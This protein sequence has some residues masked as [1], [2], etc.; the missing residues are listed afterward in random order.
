M[1]LS[2]LP[3]CDSNSMTGTNGRRSEAFK[4]GR[5][6]IAM[7]HHGVTSFW[8]NVKAGAVDAATLVNVDVTWLPPNGVFDVN[9]MAEQVS[10][11]ADS[12]LYD[13]LVVTIPSSEIASAVIQV[14]REHVGLPIVVM[15]VGMQTAAQLGV[16]AVLQDEIAAGELIGNA[17]LDRGAQDFLCL[18]HS[19]KVD[20][21]LDR[22]TGVLK[23]FLARGKK[24][25]EIVTVN[26]T[27]AFDINAMNTQESFDQVAKYLQGHPTVDTI[28]AL[29]IPT[30]NLAL[31]VSMNET[32]HHPAPTQVPGRNGTMWIGTFDVT[33]DVIQAVKNNSVAVAISQTPYVQG[34]LPVIELFLQVSTKQ[35]LI[36]NTLFT[37]PFLLNG[38]N[39][40]SEYALDSFSD[41][42]NFINRKKTAVVLNRDIAFESTRWNEA[43]GGVV[44]AASLFG[45]DTISATSMQQLGSIQ[46]ELIRTAATPNT[47]GI[48]GV[49]VS[50]ADKVQFNELLTTPALDPATPIFGLGSTANWTALPSRV[51]FTGPS[52]SGIGNVFASQILSSGY[53]VPLCL[54]EE[55][56]P[57]WQVMH[58]TELHE[59]LTKVYGGV[60]VGKLSDMMLVVPVNGSDYTNTNMTITSLQARIGTER[61]NA[62]NPILDAF[63]PTA[64][65]AFDSI[66]CTSQLLYSVVD[67]LYP[68]LRKVRSFSAAFSSSQTAPEHLRKPPSFSRGLP[69]PSSPG[70]FVV[71]I[72][73]KSLYSL[74]H[75]QQVTGLLDTQQYLQGFHAILMLS[76]RK[77]FPQRGKIFNQFLATGPV[78]INHVCEPG[79]V[80][81]SS[82][83]YG[84]LDNTGELQTM[85]VG[86]TEVSSQ[87]TYSTM[88]CHSDDGH[89]LLQS[90]CSRCAVGTISTQADAFECT[91]CPAGQ[92]TNGTGQHMCTIC[93]DDLCGTSSMSISAILA[94]VLPL[95][96]V[97]CGVGA[98]I[99]Y[100]LK[101]KRILHDKL[102]DDSWQLDLKKLLNPS[103]GGG[104]E[105]ANLPVISASGNGGGEGIILPVDPNITN[106]AM[107]PMRVVS[108]TEGSGARS[109]GAR[110]TDEKEGDG[111]LP[112]PPRST[113]SKPGSDHLNMNASTH[114]TSSNN[115][116]KLIQSALSGSNSQFS[117][118]LNT[119]SSAVGTWRSMPVFIKKIGCKKVPITAELRKEIYNMRELRHPKLV[120]FIG[121]CLAPPNICIVTEFVPKGTLAS[122]LANADHKLSWQFK[123]S[124]IEDL[125]RGMEFL[126]MSKMERHGRLTSFNCMISSRWELKI[127]GYGLDGLFMSQED[128]PLLST[129][130]PSQNQQE[131]S[132]SGH[133]H[134]QRNN[135]RPWSDPEQVCLE[136]NTQNTTSAS[137]AFESH[138]N[139]PGPSVSRKNSSS[140]KPRESGNSQYSSTAPL[141]GTFSH[142]NA[143]SDLPHVGSG[144]D[145]ILDYSAF[146]TDTMCLLWVAP[147]CLFLN[148][149]G[150][151][152]LVGTQKGDQY[153]AGII[154]N[155][156]LTRKLPYHDYTDYP[157][158]L[159]LV[160]NQDF[161]PTLLNPEYASYTAED[162][163]NIEQ[164]NNLILACI[165]KDTSL[166]PTFTTMVN[167]VN[168]IN[169]HKTDDFITS[170]AAMLEKYGN[171]M[172]D[173]VRDR[174]KNLQMRTIELEEE[175]ARTHRLLV[176]LQKAK[177]GAEA[178]ALA[179]SNFLANMSHE[180]R[181]PMNAVIGMS[182]I[183]LDS[184]L[185][186][187][188]AE[189][190]ETIE[191]SGNQ[192]MT[193][194]DD[195][196][197]YSKIESGNLKLES[198]LL[199]LGFVV[200]S[201]VNLISAQAAAKDLNLVYEIA[202]DCPVEIMGD[203]TRIRQ[204][205]LNLMSN[206]VKFTKEGSIHL[207][208]KVE[209]IQAI[210]IVEAAEEIGVTGPHRPGKGSR[211][212]TDKS[213][214][215]TREEPSKRTVIIPDGHSSSDDSNPSTLVPLAT[216]AE[217]GTPVSPTFTSTSETVRGGGTDTECLEP[218]HVFPA[219]T[220]VKLLFAVKDTGV[221]IP[222]DRF[223]KLFTSFSQVDESTTREYG[224]TGLGLAISKRLSE[225]MGGHMWV[226]SVPNVGSTFFFNIILD[227]PAG[228][229]TYQEHFEFPRLENKRLVIVSDSAPGRDAWK[230]RTDSWGMKQVRIFNSDQ[231]MSYLQERPPAA[232]GEVQS[233]APLGLLSKMETLI[234]DSD[235]KGSVA[236]TPEGLMDAIQALEPKTGTTATLEVDVEPTTIPVI[237]FKNYRD[238]NSAASFSCSQQSQTASRKGENG[239][240]WSS[241][242]GD[243][244]SISAYS[245]RGSHT[246]GSR[247]GQDRARIYG[248][249]Y[250]L[251]S[252]SSSSSLSL[253]KTGSQTTHLSGVRPFAANMLSP[254]QPSYFDHNT[255]SFDHG[256]VSVSP[257]ASLQ[258]RT[259]YFS[260]DN[261]TTS[262]HDLTMTRPRVHYDSLGQSSSLIS[263]YHR[264]GILHPLV[265]LTKPVR[266]SKI[267]Q[268]LLEDP[269]DLEAGLDMGGGGLGL[270]GGGSGMESSGLIVMSSMPIDHDLDSPLST[271]VALSSVHPFQRLPAVA[272]ALLP[273]APIM[274]GVSM[275]LSSS[276]SPGLTLD[277]SPA[278]L[279]PLNLGLKDANGGFSDSGG[280]A[281]GRHRMDSS[282]GSDLRFLVEPQPQPE[283]RA[284]AAAEVAETPV[285]TRRQPLARTLAHSTP[286]RKAVSVNADR[287]GGMGTPMSANYNNYESPLIAAAAAA[288]NSVAMRMAKMKVLVVD[289]NP[290][291]LKVASK[292]LARLGIEPE[293]ANNGQDAVE[294]I[295]RK[296]ALMQLQEGGGS[297]EG[298]APM[299][300][301][302]LAE[303]M[304]T[305]TTTTTV[306]DGDQEGAKK[307]F[308]PYDLIFMDVWMPKMNG[309]D[310]TTYI[311]KK[312]SGQSG[313]RPY[314]I[315]MTACVMEG[316]REKCIA[317]GMND[318][319][320]KP[321]RKEELEQ[322]LRTFVEH[323]ERTQTPGQAAS[324]TAAETEV[325]THVQG[326][327]HHSQR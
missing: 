248:K 16:L 216:P 317:S 137:S 71:D 323:Y 128:T 143:S 110:S 280:N 273:P 166:R 322:S 42:F 293:T 296:M 39:I 145:G 120:E 302:V 44:E 237:I 233:L 279:P 299:A 74:S 249:N 247:G 266:H 154:F 195:I 92:R 87:V 29:T 265:Y 291:N 31:R 15:N 239:S 97:I 36:Q 209:P 19:R 229:R 271:T 199:D 61:E 147:E 284:R 222:Q 246:S 255:I 66:M 270:G 8:A 153:S 114:S 202:R 220:P 130:Q 3:S 215:S 194:I 187:E 59:F 303:P 81:S 67:S 84:L 82:A 22:C 7:I 163:E 228:S 313:D 260:S 48:E 283:P 144:S 210:R 129:P 219:S 106:L 304:P 324:P 17:L 315:S 89:V 203:I 172:E 28:V 305:T 311:R 68:S 244:G 23:A 200:E 164:M 242:T 131:P 102:N 205:L 250:P 27:L 64:R 176:D 321:L 308:V 86:S 100:W 72:S 26:K 217:S 183:L 294:L 60:K 11:T 198:R 173:L 218:K 206:A 122:V 141:Q 118:V 148:S 226:E 80:F 314:V 37:G 300:D 262:P 289:D 9:A 214:K 286:R 151:Y 168:D 142:V 63:S 95:V 90:W 55:N 24:L 235:L 325:Q 326:G 319:I 251:N 277:L 1:N 169:P 51:V 211:G 133:A 101:K 180:I 177:E 57:W 297:Q 98:A 138:G 191:S 267:L 119:G 232:E 167:R 58:C 25:P 40:D 307:H 263:G 310:A 234:V 34:A 125:C 272:T 41:L 46:N 274:D 312:L 109:T 155:E 105:G 185:N 227:S 47:G 14:Q 140:E 132:N 5:I 190:A 111:S 115:T 124:F 179:K 213:S 70:V 184:K 181:T 18:S 116:N 238:V 104:P 204:I 288:S 264:F 79:T 189:C 192:L 12:G 13:G 276:R 316:D 301:G 253:D 193:V 208:V 261:E 83:S 186:P 188:L 69:D 149:L 170:M 112:L 160:K 201:A 278:A 178:A 49:I 50:L 161:R 35:K 281:G 252:D 207:S 123:F 78:P 76:I 32:V 150:D 73:P 38:S 174:T 196:L 121:V 20:S 182:R 268:A 30:V 259:S 91:A 136:H 146:E 298:V 53:A 94:I 306:T 103:L 241:D 221:G 287:N 230:I 256:S 318:Y 99:A 139:E 108:S 320:S 96:L 290:V 223:D 54:V 171:D 75:N 107:Y 157:S 43:L 127:T 10:Q 117:L 33:N 254:G 85:P 52:E 327:G 212:K 285:Q 275:T 245:M 65:L 240:R 113:G 231:V 225:L 126:H 309:L 295:E 152:E 236:R 135:S 243:D 158:V 258:R 175:R 2:N 4:D 21:V 292:M 159:E 56:G 282:G 134:H 45:W 77:M 6:R 165:S 162:R 257:A 93:T 197:D 88:L 62:T 224:G 269:A 156:I